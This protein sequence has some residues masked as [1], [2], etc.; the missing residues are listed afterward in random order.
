MT[1]VAW[2][3]LIILL[4]DGP[5]ET[6]EPLT[7]PG[8]RLQALR[9]EYEAGS[10]AFIEAFNAID[11][12]DGDEV[13]AL[14]ERWY[15]ETCRIAAAALELAEEHPG[16]EIAEEA[17]FWLAGRVPSPE[18]DEAKRIL[19]RDHIRSPRIASLFRPQLHEGPSPDSERLLREALD[20]HPDR[21]TRGLAC[22]WLARYLKNK[23]LT[24]RI[25]EQMGDDLPT[26]HPSE[27]GRYGPDFADRLVAT[28]PGPLDEEAEALFLRVVEEF[29]D[30]PHDD[31]LQH[32]E[33]TLA[34]AA[35][36][37]LYELQGLAIGSVAPEVEGEELDGRPFRLSDHRGKVVVLVFGSHFYC[38]PC[39]EHYPSD[40]EMVER[41]KDRPF[42][43]VNINVEPEKTRGELGAAW[44]DEGNTWPCLFDGG[45]DGPIHTDWNIQMYPSIYLLDHRGVIRETRFGHRSGLD[46]VV[47]GLLDELEG[48]RR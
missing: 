16:S 41:L 14:R 34:D 37:H 29:G 32:R 44:E 47:N 17:L 1:H 33:G 4:I 28:D 46:E 19:I 39:W 35:R 27:V 2:G 7:D 21:T 25:C 23:A 20:R 11:D 30:I 15:V 45:W 48:D 18:M 22:Y 5:D 13:T 42:L 24:I 31:R 12:G 38:T 40:R 26:P 43:L 9:E 6:V 3:L 10:R 36:G 8:Q